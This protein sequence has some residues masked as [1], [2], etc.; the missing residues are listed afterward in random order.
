MNW[1]TFTV[2]TSH[3]EDPSVDLRFIIEVPLPRACDIPK[4]AVLDTK[5]RWRG[6]SH[7]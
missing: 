5:L 3:P 6:G 2:D 7:E 4:G 1:Y